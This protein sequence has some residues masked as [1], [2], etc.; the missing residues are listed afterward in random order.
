MGKPLFLKLNSS[1]FRLVSFENQGK[2]L[3]ILYTKFL[4]FDSGFRKLYATSGIEEVPFLFIP[5][6]MTPYSRKSDVN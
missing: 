6:G 4:R 3:I 1:F 5:E 2:V